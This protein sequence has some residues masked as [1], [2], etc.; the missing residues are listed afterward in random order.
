EGPL[1]LGWGWLLVLVTPASF[2]HPPS[3]TMLAPCRFLPLY[4]CNRHFRWIEGDAGCGTTDWAERSGPRSGGG[5]LTV[6]GRAE[7]IRTSVSNVGRR[8]R[9][10]G[11]GA[12]TTGE[13]S[14]GWGRMRGMSPTDGRAARRLLTKS[15]PLAHYRCHLAR[16]MLRQR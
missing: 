9:H 1:W 13:C 2:R 10:A 6:L 14:A 5:G 7:N 16:T 3:E 8:G 12:K 15:A 11:Y 4:V